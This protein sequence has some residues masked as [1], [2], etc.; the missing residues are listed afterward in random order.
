MTH[1]EFLERLA[2]TLE[3]RGQ[4]AEVIA[5]TE[6]VRRDL[7]ATDDAPQGEHVLVVDGL[8]V[9]G[10][11]FAL[12]QRE[13]RL[14]GTSGEVL[15]QKTPTYFIKLDRA[16]VCQGLVDLHRALMRAASAVVAAL[17][18]L[19]QQHARQAARRRAEASLTR[20]QDRD[21]LRYI[22]VWP[23][24]TTDPPSGSISPR[25]TL[26]VRLPLDEE[27]EARLL[28]WLVEKD[29]QLAS[30]HQELLALGLDLLPLSGHE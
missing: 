21:R 4:V 19:R 15:V 22:G 30:W 9:L 5:L 29:R 14:T 26:F 8:A 10:L 24:G 17:P 1:H 18:R 20:L 25:R 16:T 3:E 12:S 2:E 7:P 6:E 28:A 27:Q 23:W 13:R 11:S